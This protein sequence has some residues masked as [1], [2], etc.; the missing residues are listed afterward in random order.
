MLQ[1][2]LGRGTAGLPPAAPVDFATL[3]LPTSPNAAL[4]APPGT[5]SERHVEIPVFNLAPETAWAL[6]RRLGDGMDRVWLTAEWPERRQAQWVERSRLANFPDL[7]NAEVR[8]L[9]GGTGLFLYSRSLTGYSD[10]GVNARRLA[11]WR[12]AFERAVATAK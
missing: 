7:V 6:L 2:L 3:R 12:A 4:A 11:A 1:L 8:P 5:T 9:P 10:F